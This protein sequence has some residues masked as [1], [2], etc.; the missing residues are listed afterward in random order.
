MVDAVGLK[1]SGEFQNLVVLELERQIADT[2]SVFPRAW[3]HRFSRQA[4]SR[5]AKRKEFRDLSTGMGI[6]VQG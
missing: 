3:D 1:H 6:T 2:R 5:A 4:F